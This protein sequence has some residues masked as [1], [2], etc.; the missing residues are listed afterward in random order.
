MLSWPGDFLVWNMHTHT[1]RKLINA[2]HR[3]LFITLVG[4]PYSSIPE[5]IPYIQAQNVGNDV[6]VNAPRHNVWSFSSCVSTSHVHVFRLAL[7]SKNE[8]TA[9]YAPSGS[10]P[11]WLG[12]DP[13]LMAYILYGTLACHPAYLLKLG[14]LKWVWRLLYKSQHQD[15]LAEK[16]SNPGSIDSNPKKDS[17]S[18]PEIEISQRR[19]S[20]SNAKNKAFTR[21]DGRHTCWHPNRNPGCSRMVGLSLREARNELS[22]AWIL[23]WAIHVVDK[24]QFQKNLI[25]SRTSSFKEA[26]GPYYVRC[27]YTMRILRFFRFR[28][29][30]RGQGCL[31]HHRGYSFEGTQ[32]TL[33]CTQCT[34][35][36]WVNCIG[37]LRSF[38]IDE[39]LAC[40]IWNV[41][42][43]PGGNRKRM[44]RHGTNNYHRSITR[45][46]DQRVSII[47]NGE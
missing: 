9:V 4:S 13:T 11:V 31:L 27:Q 43:T 34:F 47:G 8:H 36:S 45:M 1:H 14:A 10:L 35:S 20:G 2:A 18:C 19:T 33:T 26:V 5:S 12:R 3:L 29:H 21:V 41:W 7:L 15:W 40:D 22:E 24:V 23:F 37:S 30:L 32:L 39:R 28:N 46:K 17:C 16:L 25:P 38:L 6:F 44:L 42:K